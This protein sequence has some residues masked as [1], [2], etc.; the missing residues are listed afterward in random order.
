MKYSPEEAK[1][2][3]LATYDDTAQTLKELRESEP[4][5][6]NR[7]FNSKER[8]FFFDIFKDE[9]DEGIESLPAHVVR[10]KLSEDV[11]K[12][13]T[14]ELKRADGVVINRIKSTVLSHI[15]SINKIRNKRKRKN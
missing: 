1:N 9:I 3:S 5:E 10:E 4:L 8:E 7:L 15:Q 6:K 13:Y 14:V 11:I 2:F 12:F